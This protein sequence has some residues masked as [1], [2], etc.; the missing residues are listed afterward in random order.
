MAEFTSDFQ[1]FRPSFPFLDIIDHMELMN[2]FKGDN[3]ILNMQNFMMPFSNDS[4]LGSS[5]AQFPGNF[6]AASVSLPISS[7]EY[8][9]HHHEGKKRKAS[10]MRGDSSE[11][12]TPADKIK[13]V[14]FSSISIFLLTNSYA[15]QRLMF[16]FF[17]MFSELW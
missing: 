14:N 2:Q 7:P 6:S 8:E 9:T 1:S 10:Y 16:D 11:N 5:E 15:R 12:S 13:N 3:T 17:C 4:F